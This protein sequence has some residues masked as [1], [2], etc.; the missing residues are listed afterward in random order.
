MN[1]LFPPRADNTYSGY[2]LALWLFGLL[3]HEDDMTL[4]SS[5]TL[6]RATSASGIPWRRS[7]PRVA[8]VLFSFA[9]PGTFQLYHLLLGLESWFAIAVLIP[10]CFA[11]RGRNLGR[12]PSVFLPIVRTGT[13]PGSYIPSDF[14][15]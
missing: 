3:C 10:S 4:N 1:Q 15:P 6:L 13:S 7:R 2:R 5:S 9:I 14:S 11:A 8:G 12:K